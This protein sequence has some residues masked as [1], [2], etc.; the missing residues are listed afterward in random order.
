VT[1]GPPVASG[2]YCAPMIALMNDWKL[3]LFF[4]EARSFGS[5]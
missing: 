5:K 3:S 2:A 4:V 1:P